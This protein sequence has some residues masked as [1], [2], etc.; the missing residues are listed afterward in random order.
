[1]VKLSAPY[2]SSLEIAA[3]AAPLLRATFGP[4]R[5]LW[6]SDWPFTGFETTVQY[7]AMRAA[8]DVWIPDPDER[9]I[10]LWARLESE[11]AAEEMLALE[12]C[13]VQGV[14]TSGR[15]KDTIPTLRALADQLG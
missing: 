1:M 6:G 9:R 13:D 4:E 11:T 10:I 12:A 8:V 14:W 3:T 2:R 15:G 5:L 7:P